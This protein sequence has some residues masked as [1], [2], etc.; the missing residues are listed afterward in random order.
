ME[1]SNVSFKILLGLFKYPLFEVNEVKCV[2]IVYFASFEPFYV[3]GEVIWYLFPVKNPVDHVAAKQP[4]F[5]LV[6][7]VGIYLAVL[8]NRLEYVTGG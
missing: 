7:S 3:E 1:E 8:M 2:R 6:A 4:H 5:N